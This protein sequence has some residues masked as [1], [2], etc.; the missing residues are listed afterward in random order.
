MLVLKDSYVIPIGCSCINQFQAKAYADQ[1]IP[2]A[3]ARGAIFD[4]N[5]MTPQSTIELLSL[6]SSG[7]IKSV[8]CDRRNYVAEDVAEP[9]RLR[10]TAFDCLY[11]WHE[12][13][14]SVL[15][16]PP[17]NFEA[18]SS[19]VSRLIDNFLLPGTASPVAL[20]WSNI[21]PN[22]QQ[23]TS[24][25]SVTWD[26]FRLTRKT[27]ERMCAAVYGLFGSGA[28]VIFSGRQEDVDR[29]L[30]ERPDVFVMELRRSSNFRGPPGFFT[31]MLTELLQQ[32]LAA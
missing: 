26:A 13:A 24:R 28:E 7:D 31:P 25:F 14:D 29:A 21:Q 9:M 6:C 2:A 4:W 18:F 3:E 23:S 11:F 27:H 19:K 16:G 5:I 15:N 8:L 1:F 10:N 22:L 32:R 17:D 12:D 30:W 20:L